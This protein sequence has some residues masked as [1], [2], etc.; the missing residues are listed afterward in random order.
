MIVTD[1][2]RDH[3]HKSIYIDPMMV[4]NPG[5]DTIDNLMAQ[6]INKDLRISPAYVASAGQNPQQINEYNKKKTFTSI[7]ES[8][9]LSVDDMK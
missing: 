1:I 6:H 4:G 7:G 8:I 2:C 3:G 5:E 9:D